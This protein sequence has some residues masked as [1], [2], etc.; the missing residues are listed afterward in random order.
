MQA[1]QVT[2]LGQ[3]LVCVYVCVYPC[4]VL[5]KTLKIVPPLRLTAAPRAPAAARRP[6]A[7]SR[8][9]ASFE[10]AMA[11]PTQNMSRIEQP[12]QNTP[13][14]ERDGREAPDRPTSLPLR[15]RDPRRSAA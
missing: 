3:Q 13:R 2:V 6:R 4:Y 10:I 1:H 7:P 5:L 14:I 11:Q 8:R 9:Y 15:T 12:P